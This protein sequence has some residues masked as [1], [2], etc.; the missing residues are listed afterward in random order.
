MLKNARSSTTSLTTRATTRGATLIP[1]ATRSST[2]FD[3]GKFVFRLIANGTGTGGV[4][5][6]EEGMPNTSVSTLSAA[7]DACRPSGGVGLSCIETCQV[8][9]I[10]LAGTER[11]TYLKGCVRAEDGWREDEERGEYDGKHGDKFPGARAL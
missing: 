8:G 6:I 11:R 3:T 7:I 1:S 9:T 2:S 10:A 4:V 5:T